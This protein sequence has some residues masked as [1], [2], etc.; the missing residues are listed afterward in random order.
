MTTVPPR[1]TKSLDIDQVPLGRRERLWIELLSSAPASSIPATVE[2]G[3]EPGPVVGVVAAVHGDEL[4]GVAVAHALARGEVFDQLERGTLVTVPLVNLPGVMRNDRRFPDGQ[5]LNRSM[6]GPETG[7]P[8]QR[9]GTRFVERVAKKLDYLIDLHTATTHY[10]NSVYARIDMRNGGNLEL[11]RALAPPII[12]HKKAP[13]GSLRAAVN[14]AGGRAVTIELGPPSAYH[15]AAID[16]VLAGIVR[17]LHE[18][19]MLRGP[20]SPAAPARELKSGRWLRAD[21]GGLADVA[22]RPGETVRAGQT[23]ARVT[24]WWGDLVQ[25]LKAPSDGVVL[26]CL[27][28][29]LVLDGTRIIHLAVD[30]REPTDT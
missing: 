21:R 27:R 14:A 6:G 24:D 9:F 25:E 15:D 26:G 29:P 8:S 18:L 1:R 11:A 2:R 10:D 5:D 30:T 3:R 4:N 12:V 17:L 7:K 13:A 20:E 19:D 22:V 16:E 23:L 28:R